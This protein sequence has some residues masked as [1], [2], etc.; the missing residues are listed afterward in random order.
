MSAHL[1]LPFGTLV[2]FMFRLSR[3]SRL[4]RSQHSN[5]SIAS[6]SSTSSVA[7]TT[8]TSPDALMSPARDAPYATR[9]ESYDPQLNP[10]EV[11]GTD[12]SDVDSEHCDITINVKKSSNPFED[13]DDDAEGGDS[14]APVSAPV[15]ETPASAPAAQETNTTA[16]QTAFHPPPKPTRTFQHSRPNGVANST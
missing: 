1:K 10:F 2:L 12:A 5:H 9:Q 11:G 4:T 16:Q 6:Q 14:H 13:D 3:V 7:S 15:I 8:A